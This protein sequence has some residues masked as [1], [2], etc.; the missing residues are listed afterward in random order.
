M[1]VSPVKTSPAEQSNIKIEDKTLVTGVTPAD[2]ID[3]VGDSMVY[4]GE[5]CTGFAVR[6]FG[7]PHNN[8]SELCPPDIAR[9]LAK[10]AQVLIGDIPSTAGA[11][12]TWDYTATNLLAVP[13]WA[14]KISEHLAIRSTAVITVNIS[15]TPFQD[16]V[17]RCIIEPSPLAYAGVAVNWLRNSR[18]A[19]FTFPGKYLNLSD[20]TQFCIRVPWLS[21]VPFLEITPGSLTASD[22]TCPFRFTLRAYT[23]ITPPA[24][25]VAPTFS[26]FVHHEDVT[27]LGPI[28]SAWSAVQPQGVLEDLRE[29]KA[30]STVLATTSKY[31]TAL[32]GI[33]LLP[34]GLSTAGWV[35]RHAANAVSALGYSKPMHNAPNLRNTP[36]AMA[37]YTNTTGEDVADNLG[38]FHDSAVGQVDGAGTRMDEQSVAFIAAQPGLIAD[39]S[40]NLQTAGTLVYACVLSPSSMYFQSGRVNLPWKENQVAI[41]SAPFP[42]FSP[43]PVFGVS[44]MAGYWR[45]GFKFHVEFAKT[46][47]HAGRIALVFVPGSH[48]GVYNTVKGPTGYQFPPFPS[49]FDLTRKI[50]DLREVTSVDFEVP[51][52]NAS[53]MLAQQSHYG[54]FCIYVVEPIRAPATVNSGVRMLVDVSSPDL[55]LAGVVGATFAPTN[56]PN[57]IFAQGTLSGSDRVA[58]DFGEELKSVGVATKR[59]CFRPAAAAV[60]A[61]QPFSAALPT[62]TPNLT[63]P[64]A[65]NIASLD[66]I[67]YVRSAYRYE[68]G[69]MIASTHP[70]GSRMQLT[71]VPYANNGTTVGSV[72]DR[73][74]FNGADAAYSVN[75]INAIARAYVPRQQPFTY[76]KTNEGTNIDQAVL[77]REVGR[78][79]PGVNSTSFSAADAT[80]AHQYG[81]STAEDHAF[82]FFIGWPSLCRGVYT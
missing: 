49:T 82:A 27:L 46:K 42:S 36:Y 39:V 66:L 22:A 6:P 40:F 76:Y 8:T 33:P 52:V 41:S 68:R 2:D 44:A 60:L 79:A 70:F 81:R 63:A 1:G 31:A 7:I 71:T 57:N 17:L 48:D 32:G 53:P 21:N 23:A 35:L 47:F 74:L 43:S 45:G 10:P 37:N 77:T 9:W 13:H 5:A 18:A 72:V 4:Q 19:Q 26:V 16:G 24:G 38:L 69:G 54:Y 11:T 73:P 59:T 65:L 28:P 15:A 3:A 58:E 14:D 29:S 12:A 51:Y 25:S 56:N 55:K 61:A 67:D 30:I 50:V 75:T 78:I 62:Y 34:R 20:T 80:L 64:T